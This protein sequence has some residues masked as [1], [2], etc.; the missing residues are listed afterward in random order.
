M[1]TTKNDESGR[2]L[3]LGAGYGGLMAALRA[4]D[5]APV[6]LV[7]PSSEFTER[8][9]QHELAAGRTS[10]GHPLAPLLARKGVRHVPA[11]ATALDT[12]RRTVT[13]NSGEELRY[14]RLVYALGSRTR[15]ADVDSTGG[16][17]GRVFTSETAA[18]LHERLQDGRGRLTVVGGGA[19]G[20]ETASEIAE[21]TDW[22]VE[23]V[24]AGQ[25]GPSLSDKGRAHVRQVL[26]ALGVTLREG[27]A[28]TPADLDADAVVWNASLQ[29]TTEPATAAGI[30]LGADGRITVDEHLRSVSH[31]EVFAAGDAAGAWTP[32]AGALR[33]ACATALPVGTRAGRNAAADLT[34]GE[35]RPLRFRYQAQVL[36]LGRH[37]GLVQ[38]VRRDDSPTD[39]VVTGRLAALA[40]EQVVRSTVRALRIAAR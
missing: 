17:D 16:D 32:D 7:D 21:L 23:L 1:E 20:I 31:P 3:V 39:L 8:V 19:T 29:P 6:T 12:R 36:S 22:E 40:K 30:L 13:T 10:I 11:R 14:D 24:T 25:V 38:K 5:H 27:P 28:V 4:A 26:R 37:D 35:V 9:R 18:H 33:M 34:G 2:V 15:G